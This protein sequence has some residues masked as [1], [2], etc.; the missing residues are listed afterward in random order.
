MNEEVTSI[1]G[2]VCNEKLSAG[3]IFAE[4]QNLTH[5]NKEALWEIFEAIGFSWSNTIYNSNNQR[6]S[7][8]EML[9]AKTENA[10]NYTGE[11]VNAIYVIDELKAMYGKEDAYKK[12]FFESNIDN[13]APPTTRLAHCKVY[14]VNEFIRMQITAGGFKSWG[15]KYGGEQAKNYH[16]FLGGTRYNRISKVRAYNPDSN[17][18]KNE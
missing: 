8:Y 13:S 10:P 15:T 7:W 12:L 3:L 2:S 18:L 5:Q 4:G 9:K 16:G 6:S 17:N 1:G 14:V 11:Y